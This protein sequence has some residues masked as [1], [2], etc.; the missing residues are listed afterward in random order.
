M[1]PSKVMAGSQRGSG[2]ALVSRERANVL[3]VG[4]HAIDMQSAVRA[5]IEAA[6]GGRGG[7]VCVTGV[8]GVM[9]AQR[10]ARLRRIINDAFLV[11]PD[12]MPTVWVGRLQGHGRMERVY[13]PDLMLEVCRASVARNLSHFIYGGCEG[14]AQELAARLEGMFPGIEIKGTY[15]PPFRP[16]DEGE[17]YGLI[18]RVSELRPDIFW[19]G[20]STPKQERLMAGLF[21]RLDTKVMVG[22]GAAFDIH[23]GR[24]KDAPG[25]VKRAGLQ[26]LHRTLSEPRRLAGRYFNIVPR[27]LYH[28][29][30]Q[31]TGIKKHALDAR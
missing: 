24:T 26:W 4:V 9:E 31:L 22:V 3:G 5:I 17:E 7:Y 16:L 11:T 10:D 23:T 15:T 6:E 2:D 14:V 12:G 13:G 21:G 18:E 19:V 29:S 20:L 25:W 1:L 8:H 27:F 28:I 30:L